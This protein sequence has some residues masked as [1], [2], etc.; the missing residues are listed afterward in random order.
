MN[1]LKKSSNVADGMKPSK[2][3]FIVEVNAKIIV[4]KLEVYPDGRPSVTAEVAFKIGNMNPSMHNTVRFTIPITDE[5]I[6]YC[7]EVVTRQVGEIIKH[8]TEF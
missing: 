2:E 1:G 4:K 7:E 5:L 8:E 6:K 3:V